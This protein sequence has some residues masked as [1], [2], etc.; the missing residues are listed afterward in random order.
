[1]TPLE[2][3]LARAIRLDSG[4]LVLPNHRDNP[5]VYPT[6]RRDEGGTIQVSRMVWLTEHGEFDGL[7]CHTCDYPRCFAIEHLFVGTQSDNMKDMAAK[8]RHVYPSGEEHYNWKGGVVVDAE[9]HRQWLAG[10]SPEQLAER[11]RRNAERERARR[12]RLRESKP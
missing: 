12:A 1:M 5:D 6:M 3:L 9:Y 11:R 4:C 2:R 8:N 10:R 7:I